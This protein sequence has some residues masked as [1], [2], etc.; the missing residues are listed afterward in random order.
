MTT[1]T[2]LQRALERRTDTRFV[3]TA[4]ASQPGFDATGDVR[5][6]VEGLGGIPDLYLYVDSGATWYFPRG[7]ADLPCPT[8]CYLIDVH[9]QPK[10]RRMQAMFFDYAF[11]AQRDFVEVLRRAG[12]PQAHWLPLACDPEIHRRYDVPLRYDI[13]FVGSVKSEY[14][15][16]SALLERLTRRFS[17]NDYRRRYTPSEMSEVYS[18][19]RMVFNCSLNDEVNMRVFEGPATGTLLLTDRIG[20]GL[21]NLVVDGE[22]VVMYDDDRLVELAEQYL[23]DDAARQRIAQQG[24]EH[25]R[26]QHTYDQRVG[27]LLDT[28]FTSTPAMCAPLR[29]RSD[30]DVQLAYAELASRMGRVDDTIQQFAAVPRRLR[31]RLPA[32]K[33]I[34]YCL[35]RRVRYG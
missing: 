26:A 23:R 8:A 7:I 24:Y 6:V 12:H 5:E 17:V 35:I 3:G 21:S 9:V 32:L 20:N 19:S 28:V 4:W 27:T 14:A 2:Y 29:R 11:S 1:A 10:E 30:P 16:R 13:G 18:A 25:V 15:R 22:H 31:Y 33:Q 34:V